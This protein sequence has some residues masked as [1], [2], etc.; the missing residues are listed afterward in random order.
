MVRL[1]T[2]V[3]MIALCGSASALAQPAPQDPYANPPGKDP[4]LSEQIAEQ[5]VARAQELYDAKIYVDAKQLAV[6]ALVES[7]K[8]NAAEHA[9]FIIR[10]VNQQLGIRDDLAPPPQPPPQTLPPVDTAPI[11]DPTLRHPL[12]P[13]EPQ[14]VEG[15]P[16]R[17]DG[18]IIAMGYGGFYGGAVGAWIGSYFS[19]DHPAAGAVPMG[20]VLGAGAGLLAPRLV[21]KWHVDE[22]QVRTVGAASF[23]VAS[24]G[25]FLAYSIQTACNDP[26]G[27]GNG[28]KASAPGVLAGV[29]LGG[30]AGLLAGIGFAKDKKLTR[31]DVALVDTFA[32]V[33]MAGGLTIGMLM[34][35]AQKGAYTLNGA[36]G[37]GAGVVTAL[38]LAPQTNTTPRRM[39]RVA[40]LAAAGGA[41]PMLILAAGPHDSGVQRAAG[42][43]ATLGLAAGTVLGF[44][45]TRHMDEGLDVHDS[46]K[47]AGAGAAPDNHDVPVNPPPP[48]TM[49]TPTSGTGPMTFTLP[50]AFGTF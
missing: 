46:A 26:M 40:G 41:V 29:A 14:P 27:C 36:L 42:G 32:G 2:G 1:R 43:L 13:V 35:P 18:K 12:P 37:I 24:A 44:Y 23:W 15:G 19:S 33:G 47:P 6:E 3:M 16:I 34:Q 17:D 45:L 11:D 4:V 21:D 7:P 49:T 31:G 50:V 9:K 39:L 10:Q 28:G 48:P 22:S 20:V 30:S 38:V 8:G 5:L 25:G